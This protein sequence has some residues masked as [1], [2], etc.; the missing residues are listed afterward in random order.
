VPHSRPSQPLNPG[1]PL[2]QGRLPG[3]RRLDA[4]EG[5]YRNI[6]STITGI[7]RSMDYEQAA[8]LEA[9]LLF[10]SA[11]GDGQI[12]IDLGICSRAD[13]EYIDYT[14]EQNELM[15]RCPHTLRF[16]VE[17]AADAADLSEEILFFLSERESNAPY[18]PA[19]RGREHSHPDPSGPEE[20]FETLF[21]Q[22]FGEAARHALRREWPFADYARVTR[23]VDYALLTQTKT[24]GIELN[25]ESFHHPR[26]IGIDR[27]RSQL[28]KQNSLVKS[29]LT[30]FRWS[31]RG[32]QDENRFIE[33]MRRFFGAPEDFRR[34]PQYMASRKLETFALMEHQEDAL[35]QIADRRTQGKNAFLVVLP[36]GT[37]K[38]EVV[39]Q[40]FRRCKGA[41][42]ELNG[43][44]LAP[45]LN[46]RDQNL[47]Y[48]ERSLA[49]WNHLTHYQA[50][51]PLA[52]FMVQTYQHMIRHYQSYA[53]DA[54][55][56]IVVDESHHAVAAGL[57]S[58]LE[59]FQPQ[60]LIG[61]TATDERLDQKRLE[62]VF[63]S[64][65]T[66]LSLRDAIEKELLP[67]I[68]AFRIETNVSLSDVRFNGHDY[69]QADLQRT[70]LVRSR[71]EVV[72]DT[73]VKY[74]GNSGVRKQGVVFCV[75]VRHANDMAAVLRA[76]GLSAVS[77][78]GRDRNSA[79]AALQSYQKGEVQ[80]LCACE[81]ISEGWD[82][83]QTSVVVMA[84]PTMSKVL[85]VQ[86]LGR[87]T[88]SYPGKEAL[89]VLDVVD[90]HGPLNA[91][92]SVHAL[93]GTTIYQPWAN[94]VGGEHENQEQEILLGWL[95]ESERRVSE[96]DIFTFQEKY[97]GYLSEEQLARELFVSTGTIRAWLKKGDIK[98]DVVVPFGS[99]QLRYFAPDQVGRIRTLKGLK[100]HD[101][102]TQ[103]DDFFEF[104]GER[105]YTFSYKIIFMLALLTS[106][107][108]RGEAPVE[109]LAELYRGFYQDRLRQGLPVER[110]KSPYHRREML[111]D[112]EAVTRSIME[113]PFEKFERK[114][115]LHHCKDLAYIAW[116]SSLWQRF[117]ASARDRERVL[118]QMAEDLVNYYK[119]LGGLGNT[120]Y[121]RQTFP[122]FVAFLPAQDETVASVVEESIFVPFD[123][124]AAFK[125]ILPFYPLEVAAGVFARSD[126][127]SPE[128]EGWVAVTGA[129]FNRRL[130]PDMFVSRVFGRSMLPLIPDGALCVFRR[131]VSGSREGRVVLVRKDDF[132]DPETRASFTV[133]RY[134]STKSINEDGWEHATI[135]LHP[136]NREFPV[137]RF[138]PMSEGEL[139][140]VAEFIAVLDM[141]RPVP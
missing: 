79:A 40:D 122:E 47:A 114:R 97:E 76:R 92:W 29:G 110:T 31:L 109:K 39:A 34:T 9:G 50:R 54:F 69:V 19:K 126:V 134:R 72:A 123:H 24:V 58:V 74:F 59:H 5:F 116:Q 95:H 22:A 7:L 73:L 37:G 4:G 108:A 137:L 61:L 115:F 48:V 118:K 56:Y 86:Q 36:T 63:G 18:P 104:I 121:L 107:N 105:D 136:D 127:A 129:G 75:N 117:A 26:C 103:Y 2:E 131:G 87:G 102:S 12:I 140:T 28:F 83:P 88:R 20:R 132:S 139:G 45:T 3:I 10:A 71:D 30:V 100:V 27:Y 78:S 124:A 138:D 62:E 1:E 141:P 94:L 77:V 119:E 13:L 99:S 32:M 60:T 113:N 80:F 68:R 57:R 66:N 38:T 15:F 42:P 64:Y 65:E 111:E 46:L 43:L 96:I 33:E 128:P 25:G 70:L 90:K 130:T 89:Y 49:G 8:R 6:E 91:P 125:T 120:E 11:H 133:K 101:A 17:S 98:P 44:I 53:P 52:G 67:P 106:A 16:A 41:Q 55:D 14:R 81:L 21:A 112:P 135:E 82:A 84:R 85:Y 51:A 23:Y 93:F 35:N